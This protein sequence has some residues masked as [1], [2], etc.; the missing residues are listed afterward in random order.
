MVLNLVTSVLDRE[1]YR[2][3]PMQDAVSA[4]HFAASPAGRPDL[5]L[6]DV[7]MPGLT[8]PMLAWLV[9]RDSPGTRILYMTAY[10]DS[11]DEENGIPARADVLR[12]P[13]S[14][15]E[16]VH[17]VRRA[18]KRPRTANLKA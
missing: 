4:L 14:V 6:T 7:T 1:G 13:F 12:K 3:F 16:L 9:H 17:R 18:L 2:V 5:L 11:Q 15:G 8:G 10:P